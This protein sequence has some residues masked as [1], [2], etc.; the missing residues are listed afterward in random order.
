VSLKDSFFGDE[1]YTR[2]SWVNV[3]IMSFHVLTGYSA[4]MSFSNSIFESAQGADCSGLSPKVGTYLVGLCNL[5]AAMCGIY[6]VRSFGRRT[7]L[8]SGHLAITVLH[9]MIGFATLMGWSTV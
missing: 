2:A 6:T 8:L 9:F 5:L 1:R 7:V 4:V 3:A